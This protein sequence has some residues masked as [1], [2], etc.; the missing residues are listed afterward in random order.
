MISISCD[1]SC[2]LVGCCY[3]L[4]AAGRLVS[5]SGISREY[6]RFWG[7]A[8]SLAL[9]RSWLDLQAGYNLQLQAVRAGVSFYSIRKG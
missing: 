2:R 7:A 4:A 8:V 3:R 1:L 5:A 6:K 9:V